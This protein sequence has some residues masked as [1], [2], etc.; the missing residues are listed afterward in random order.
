MIALELTESSRRRRA[1][2][3]AMGRDH[4]MEA[5][6]VTAASDTLIGQRGEAHA[7]R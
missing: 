2:L 4:Q 6:P 1:D 3:A 5:P 7:E